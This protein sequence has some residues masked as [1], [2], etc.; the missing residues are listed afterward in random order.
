[1]GQSFH[2]MDAETVLRRLNEL[3]YLNGGVVII[4][5]V[6]TGQNRLSTAKDTV[7]NEH[8]SSY[9]GPQRRAGKYAYKKTGQ[10]REA[11]LFPNSKFTHIDR[12]DYYTDISRNINQVLGNI[13]SMSWSSKYQLGPAAPNFEKELRQMLNEI[14]GGKKFID[15]VQFS[16]YIL[17]K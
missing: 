17:R 13:F 16:M 5:S 11:D 10:N 4:K 6:P 1:M 9:L 3:L 8:I 7:I 2:W 14:A 12:Y 15:R